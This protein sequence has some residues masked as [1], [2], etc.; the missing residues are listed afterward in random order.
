M[1]IVI[2]VCFGG[3]GISDAGYEQLIKWGVPVRKHI[4]E[5]CDPKNHRYLPEP[6]NDGEVIFDRSLND[7]T[8]AN[9]DTQR[10]CGR[11]WEKWLSDN[12]THPMLVR[13]VE[14]IGNK[15]NG[16]YAKLKVIEI[17]DDIDWEI[18]EYDGNESIE[19]KHRS[20]S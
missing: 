10:L 11:Y 18:N 12:R 17:P 8:Q 13:L 20:W 4:P 14:E 2:N 16:I 9:R 3:F 7:N 1:K 6:A 19:E 15:V 5:K